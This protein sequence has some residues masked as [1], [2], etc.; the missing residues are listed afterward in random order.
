MPTLTLKEIPIKEQ[1]AKLKEDLDKPLQS[2]RQEQIRA[3]G[4]KEKGKKEDW[5]PGGEKT[6]GI[7]AAFACKAVEHIMKHGDQE[8]VPPLIETAPTPRNEVSGHEFS[9]RHLSKP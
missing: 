3:R 4:V 1:E 6:T 7:C 5:N 9:S 8:T 2:L